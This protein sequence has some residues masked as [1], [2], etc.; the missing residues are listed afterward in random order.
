MQKTKSARVINIFNFIR[1]SHVEP[2]RFI[3]DDYDAIFNQIQILKKYQMPST[4]ALKYDA[5]MEPRYQ[6][7]IKESLDE[8]DEVGIWWEITGEM[9]EKACICSMKEAGEMADN[10][11]MTAYSLGYTKEERR[12]LLDVYMKDFHQVFGYYPKTIASWVIDIDTLTYAKEKYGIKGAAI[13]RDQL[14]VDGFTLW[15]GYTNGAYYPSVE[16]EFI[17]AQTLEQQLKLPV[18]RLLGPDPI[19]NWEDGIR[20]GLYGVHSLE[21][22]CGVGRDS[23]WVN[24]MFD[25]L[26]TEDTLGM[27][28]AQVGQENNFL[29]ENI[30][31]GFELQLKKISQLREQKKVRVET[32]EESSDW[33][34][35]KYQMTPPS[36]YQ[37]SSDWNEQFQLK[38]MWY[39]C[40]NYRVSFL[41]EK[42]QL[43]I[44][45][46]F[47]YHEGYHSR[48]KDCQLTEDAST[49]DALP[50]L[51]SRV[52]ST[53]KKRAAIEF[54]DDQLVPITIDQ[55]TFLAKDDQRARVEVYSKNGQILVDTSE[56]GISFEGN[57]NLYL[58]AVPTLRHMEQSQLT[59]C[60][61]G[62]YYSMRVTGGSLERYQ[63][64]IL[65][66]SDN[67]HMTLILEQIVTEKQEDIYTKEYQENPEIWDCY[68]SRCERMAAKPWSPKQLRISEVNNTIVHHPKEIIDIVSSTRFD[69]RPVFN[70]EGARD[71]LRGVRGSL[72][73][74]DGC[75]LGTTDTL[76]V[77][78]ELKNREKISRVIIG[79]HSNH[80]A[81]IL[82]PQS[83][84]CYVGDSPDQMRLAESKELKSGPGERE[85][86]KLDVI[87]D[88]EENAKFIQV[89]AIP[90]PVFPDWCIY[91]GLPGVF[92]MADALMV[93]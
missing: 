61:E 88:L 31:P 75:W 51:F 58:N 70:K 72:D 40:K 8:Y 22:S 93:E 85:I 91:R 42:H 81:G 33:F 41:V 26:A 69:P 45:D 1:Q 34:Q 89:K 6:K 18:F 37:A 52:W 56:E 86:E 19:Y 7:L 11:V 12:K 38:T 9:C 53:S 67:D 5:L 15:G 21:P 32:L 80:R 55:V 92:T 25:S 63:D 76:D 17:P 71:L 79:F 14:G 36:T 90:Y 54:L 87:F 16:N 30:Q 68:R 64:G 29:W 43:S 48:Y 50:I 4:F 47:V 62:F 74:Q 23:H 84:L 77:T 65:I 82:Y 28:Y 39:Q 27:A 83:V 59:F 66:R 2:S 10:R 35:G 46:L 44:R 3:Q 73:Y 24:W 20:P 60:H 57:L 13:C 49:M 78:A